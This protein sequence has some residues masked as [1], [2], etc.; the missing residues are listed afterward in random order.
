MYTYTHLPF[1]SLLLPPPNP[2]LSHGVEIIHWS[3]LDLAGAMSL[4][5][6]ILP[7]AEAINSQ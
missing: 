6:M 5:Q 1:P 3:I 2:Q 4:R 7:P